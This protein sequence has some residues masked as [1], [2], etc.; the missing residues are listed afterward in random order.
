MTS[1]WTSRK[2]WVAIIAGV[3]GIVTTIWGASVGTEVEVIAG[4][5]L[6]IAAALGYITA[7][8]AVDAAR[9]KANQT[10]SDNTPS[11]KSK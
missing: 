9:A 11:K 6:T 10:F 7:E 2:F 8:A 3:S 5:I 4:A 1:K